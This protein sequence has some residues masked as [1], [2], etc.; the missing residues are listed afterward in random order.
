M[1][2][3][4]KNLALLQY[5]LLTNLWASVPK[6]SELVPDSLFPLWNSMRFFAEGIT[7]RHELIGLSKIRNPVLTKFK[8]FTNIETC[9]FIL[10]CDWITYMP[11]LWNFQKSWL[12]TLP[13][14]QKINHFLFS[15]TW[16]ARLKYMY[17]GCPYMLMYS[18]LHIMQCFSQI[19]D[20]FTPKISRNFLILTFSWI[21]PNFAYTRLE[22]IA[23]ALQV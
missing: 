12:W 5:I 13:C 2:T 11:A 19:L 20:A 22:A 23:S 7:L 1:Y 4:Y 21:K 16:S 17:E 8:H 15:Q 3:F 10:C 18:A 9:T 14:R 6:A